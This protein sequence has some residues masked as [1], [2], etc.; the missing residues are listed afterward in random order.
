[1]HFLV[2]NDDG[3]D[4]PGINALAEL[5]GEWGSVTVVAPSGP[6]SGC[7]HQVT[8]DREVTV[9]QLESNRFAVSGTPADCVRI[10]LHCLAPHADWTIAGIND[11]GNLG[12]DIYHSGTVAAAREAALF[13]RAAVAISQYRAAGVVT[14][15]LVAAHRAQL[16]L[17][18][19]LARSVT[20]PGFWNVN[21]P[22]TALRRVG[23]VDAAEAES[24]AT[25]VSCEIDFSQLPVAFAQDGWR[26]RYSGSYHQRLR[27]QGGDIDVC[28]SG[29]IALSWIRLA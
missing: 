21:L 27:R 7:S 9:E 19:I 13:G 2:T 14:D 23:S 28:F 22:S 15:W 16:A 17:D 10:G 1:M 24:A 18:T 6:W 29:N 5:L 4:A 26:F 25:V 11:G 20:E 12:V 8:V 3:I